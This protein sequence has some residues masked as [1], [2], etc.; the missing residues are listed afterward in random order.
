M[1]DC[2]IPLLGFAFVTFKLAVITVC[3]TIAST[4]YKNDNLICMFPG[5]MNFGTNLAPKVVGKCYDKHE[6]FHIHHRVA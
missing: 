3:Q 4:N 1:Q 2:Q 6:I 5:T